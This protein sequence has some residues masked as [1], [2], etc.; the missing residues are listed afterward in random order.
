MNT[1]LDKSYFTPLYNQI[2]NKENWNSKK[3]IVFNN[4]AGTGKSTEAHRM[5]GELSKEYSYKALYVQPYEKDGEL[6][7]TVN[8]INSFA[9]KSI[10][11]RFAKNDKKIKGE[12]EKA[13]EAQILCITHRMYI[14]ICKGNNRDLANGRDI[15]IIDELPSLLNK[16]EITKYDIMEL[17]LNSAQY[18]E[19]EKLATFFKDVWFKYENISNHNK[20]IEFKKVNYTKEDC[21]EYSDLIQVLLNKIEDKKIKETLEKFLQ[22][23]NNGF[24]FY[25]NKFCS[26]DGR[27]KPLL[28]KNNIILDANAGFNYLYQL[29]PIFIVREQ[30]KIFEYSNTNLYH[31]L[32]NTSKNGIN[33]SVDLYSKCLSQVM[34]ET[35]DSVL[36]VIDKSHI[37][38]LK[39]EIILNY[40]MYGS[41]IE[42][43]ET[44][45]GIKIYIDYHGNLIGKNT[46]R[47]CNI[48][49][50]LKTPNFDYQT[51]TL[52]YL[53]YKGYD[54]DSLRDIL[55]FD[56]LEI[57]KLRKSNVAGEIYQA[58]KRINRNNSKISRIYL[59][60]NNKDIID[61]V[62]DQFNNIIYTQID[63]GV[64]NRKKR[65]KQDIDSKFINQIQ[66]TKDLIIKAIKNGDIEIRK[67]AMRDELGIKSA[68]NFTPIV[69]ELKP[70]LIQNRII[71]KWQTLEFM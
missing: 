30:E 50:I 17:W 1:I 63:L 5:L 7:N 40:N 45:M 65:D 60:N 57:E 58:I 34:L 2:N 15:L 41:T 67:K 32:V 23:L 20:N 54:K 37:D 70:W 56:N 28:L 62:K 14:E 38:I 24:L 44:N 8:R 6:T 21:K 29:S 33:N 51:Y 9:G 42:E 43:I 25:E 59:F 27:I 4:E 55:V 64:S 53:F 68:S 18:K 26:Y 3:F 16:I 61:I 49:V 48:A 46:Y 11:R 31:Y 22:L 47:D 13:L 69:D 71:N 66:L 36:F 39:D 35:G 52:N 10:A 19:A 12:R